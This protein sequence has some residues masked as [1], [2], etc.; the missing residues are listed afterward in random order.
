[1][2][3]IAHLSARVPTET[4]NHFKALA[5]RRGQAVQDLLLQLV[6]D[7]IEAETQSPPKRAVIVALLQAHRDELCA[8][9]IQ[10]LSLVGSFARDEAGIESDI[11]LV[12]EFDQ[13]RKPDLFELSELRLK[14]E[15]W[16]ENRFAVD[17]AMQSTLKPGVATNMA[18][19]CVKIF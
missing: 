13:E 1:M 5:A 10:H 17:L 4:R 7:F 3:D 8:L 19:D 15:S 18:A 11:D 14:I 9:G 12:L 6:E 16:F 2:A